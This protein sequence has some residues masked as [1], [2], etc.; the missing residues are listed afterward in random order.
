MSHHCKQIVYVDAWGWGLL[1]MGGVWERPE[2]D[3][4]R[5]VAQQVVLSF[6][7]CSSRVVLLSTRASQCVLTAVQQGCNRICCA[8]VCVAAA[9]AAEMC[10]CSP[11]MLGCVVPA[12]GYG[13]VLTAISLRRSCPGTNALSLHHV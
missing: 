13:I 9:M 1:C 5:A 7:C 3:K 12:P 10:G 11:R 4:A 8:P 6:C 2:S